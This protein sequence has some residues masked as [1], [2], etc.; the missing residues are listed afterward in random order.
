[1]YAH[2]VVLPLARLRLNMVGHEAES[3]PASI[4]LTFLDEAVK[5]IWR[6]PKIFASIQRV[7]PIDMPDNNI[8]S[9][10]AIAIS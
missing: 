8:S 10:Y 9:G 2:H 5:L 4:S 6:H 7:D 1:M 3:L